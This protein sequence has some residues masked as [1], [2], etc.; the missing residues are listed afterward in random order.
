M[1]KR[2]FSFGMITWL[3]ILA[4]AAAMAW[5]FFYS[6]SSE[7]KKIATLT[8]ASD[9]HQQALEQISNIL[10]GYD[11]QFQKIAEHSNQLVA[12]VKELD[13]VVR[14]D[15]HTWRLMQV[16]NFLEMAMVQ[17]TL[18]NDTTSAI[19]LLAAAENS[20]KRIDNANL[21]PVRKAIQNDILMLAN[22]PVSNVGTI[23]LELD[24]MIDQVPTLPHKIRAQN[25]T[26]PEAIA[27]T[28]PTPDWEKRV[29]TTWQEIKSL[30]RI[31][32]HDQPVTPYFSKDDIWLINENLSL[33]LEQASFAAARH[34][35][36]LYKK[37]LAHA[38]DWLKQYY[39]LNDPAV[40][41]V[42][43]TLEDLAKLPVASNINLHLN[44]VDAW[45]TFVNTT[46]TREQ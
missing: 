4:L 45:G 2:F 42:M 17:A 10:T 6:D 40:Q 13:A 41:K 25:Q 27:P 34:Y 24:G 23:V 36:P 18:L 31:Q 20:L 28:P 35:E 26:Q 38:Q 14:G 8:E 5:Q 46:N 16:Q 1:I 7:A 21:I 19:N 12:C 22:H 43:K 3:A 9:K 33:I 44:T 11:Q 39:D 30:V 29:S 15:S 37:Q 32:R